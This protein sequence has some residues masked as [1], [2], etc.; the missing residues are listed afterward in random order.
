MV[1]PKR[2]NKR[3]FV[4][5]VLCL[6]IISIGV[7]AQTVIQVKG[8]VYGVD[9]YESTPYKLV[10]AKVQTYCVGDSAKTNN[11]DVT[12]DSGRLGVM[13]SVWNVGIN[14]DTK[15]RVHLSYVGM[16]PLDTLCAPVRKEVPGMF[17]QYVV[18]LDSIVLHSKPVTLEEAQVVAELKKM[19]ES[20]DTIIFNAQAY[21]MPTGSVLLELV[22]RLPGLQYDGKELTYNG[23]KIQ[24]IKLN[25]DKFFAHDLSIA[26]KNMPSEKI[27][28][29]KVYEEKDDTLNVNSQ[30]HL[31]M[32]M[33]TDKLYKDVVFAN[34]N[35]TVHPSPFEFDAGADANA[36]RR[37]NYNASLNYTRQ[38]IPGAKFTC[39][40]LNRHLLSASF[41][42]D[43]WY[44]FMVTPNFESENIGNHTL[45]LEENMLP[46]FYN[47]TVNENRSTNK[48]WR[49]GS[50]MPM[51]ISGSTTN[52]LGWSM[53]LAAEYKHDDQVAE[54]NK[55]TYGANP[56]DGET[57]GELLSERLLDDIRINKYDQS[58]RDITNALS[59]EWNGKLTKRTGD[60]DYGISGKVTYDDTE[61]KTYDHS[62]LVYSQLDSTVVLNRMMSRPGSV[63]NSNV[64][65]F[66]NH[67]FGRKHHWGVEYN[68]KVSDSHN[69]S[70]YYDMD[71]ENRGLAFLTS[72]M[73]DGLMQVDSL[74]Y[75]GTSTSWM[76]ALGANITFDWTHIRLHASAAAVPTFH[77]VST[78][79]AKMAEDKNS[80]KALLYNAA[81]S[82]RYS[83]GGHKVTVGYNYNEETP[84]ARMLMN[85]VDYSDPLNVR[86]GATELT[87]MMRHRFSL[88]YAK[89][90]DLSLNS[91]ITL[92]QNTP[93][94]KVTYDPMTGRSISTP[95][96]I[97]G[98]W[99]AVTNA[100]YSFKLFKRS[101]SFSASHVYHHHVNYL[102][103]MGSLESIKGA[104][105][106]NNLRA[107][108]NHSISNKSMMVRL[109]LD[110]NLTDMKNSAYGMHSTQGEFRAGGYASF[111]LPYGLELVTDA[112]YSLRH[113][114][115]IGELNKNRFLLNMQLGYSFLKRKATVQLEWKDVFHQVRNIDIR[116]S[117]YMRTETRTFGNTSMVLAT[118]KYRFNFLE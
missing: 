20:G 29:L 105:D 117:D 71:D 106:N 50:M 73:T 3:L 48:G 41:M 52:G 46:G 113:G 72:D 28:S 19:Y 25:G 38:G 77:N 75:R 84:S 13:Y 90:L 114:Y 116:E 94:N 96:P 107:G 40:D 17:T 10:G 33:V 118:F 66:Y 93:S 76:H 67:S 97:N 35:V 108:L 92:D 59:L 64:Q 21:E 62:S 1:F 102:R 65:M 100:R 53:S 104:T 39:E 37:Q 31:V 115:A 56:Y 26:L 11:T 68:M 85:V 43:K 83:G 18:S 15:I 55:D 89:G 9:E 23:R 30:K 80:Y 49:I 57:G 2:M 36:Y 42:K 34:A 74:S 63:L 103:Q 111:F 54:S 14:K 44:N 69:K 61:Q 58:R 88:D 109:S 98:N 45:V 22:R 99:M 5:S 70:T 27:K 6:W 82:T 112:N 91:N 24:E 110:Y 51:S 78:I 81:L 32:D 60:N 16:E 95:V 4:L 101:F 87:K 12:D 86:V 8:K 7:Q 47:Y 79:R